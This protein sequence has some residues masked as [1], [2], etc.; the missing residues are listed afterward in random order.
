[1]DEAFISFMKEDEKHDV[2]FRFKKRKKET[3]RWSWL[4]LYLKKWFKRRTEEDKIE[5]REFIFQEKY[6][7]IKEAPEPTN[8]IWNSIANSKAKIKLGRLRA[9][10]WTFV[11]AS[12]CVFII[13]II[14]YVQ[15]IFVK[16][17]ESAESKNDENKVIFNNYI[18]TIFSISITIIIIFFNK[19]LLKIFIAKI[20]KYLIFVSIMNKIFFF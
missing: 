2:L 6:L 15:A 8:I 11:L 3:S 13:Y 10:F 17:A 7:N 19:F 14:K 9:W 5:K 4:L 12:V 16:K 20:L 1:M 18:V